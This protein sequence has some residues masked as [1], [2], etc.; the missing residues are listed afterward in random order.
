MEKNI[1]KYMC[2]YIYIYTH[3]HTHTHTH[4]LSH[5]ICV[6]LFAILWTVAHHFCP[7]DSPGKNTGVGCHAILQRIFPTHDQTHISYIS[8]CID[9]R[10][11]TT[12]PPGKANLYLYLYL[13]LSHFAVQQ[14]LTYCKSIKCKISVMM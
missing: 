5:F 4:T 12:A 6:Q 1:K 7:W 2:V 3:T 8:S 9:R 14:K 11:F 13:Y 10:F